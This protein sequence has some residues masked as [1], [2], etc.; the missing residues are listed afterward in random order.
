MVLYYIQGEET[1]KKLIFCAIILSVFLAACIAPV[2]TPEEVAEESSFEEVDKS[3]EEQLQEGLADKVVETV[4][5]A[6]EEPA[7][8]EPAPEEPKEAA[9]EIT[10]D[11]DLVTLSE[12]ITAIDCTE[13]DKTL[14]FTLTNPLGKTLALKQI[15]L[16][17]AN[18]KLPFT[19]TI[20][21]RVAR[22]LEGWC[23]ATSLVA[24]ATVDCTTTFIPNKVSK[25]LLVRTGQNSFYEPLGNYIRV[26][27]TPLKA[28]ANFRCH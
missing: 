9:E 25:G 12:F 14:R 18:T 4:V 22:D 21:G 20:N 28:E 5:E 24:D 1:M 15:S 2:E 6:P 19:L 3:L 27:T 26:K 11:S 10:S 17:Q 7:P 13:E 16:L 8:E 23:G